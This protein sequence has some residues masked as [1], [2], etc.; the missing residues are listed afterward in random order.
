M[1]SKFILPLASF[2]ASPSTTPIVFLPRPHLPFISFYASEHS[3]L[4]PFLRPS[5]PPSPHAVP[6]S[7]LSLSSRRTLFPSMSL[8]V[9]LPSSF[10]TPCLLSLATPP[11]ASFFSVGL[12]LPSHSLTPPRP[13]SRRSNPPLI[14][15]WYFWTVVFLW[16]SSRSD[17]GLTFFTSPHA[18]F[19]L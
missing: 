13:L 17:S 14:S 19:F 6:V 18:A 2:A 15:F 10:L 5:L 7:L 16:P 1:H 9:R 8:N 4:P 12:S 11:F 3:P